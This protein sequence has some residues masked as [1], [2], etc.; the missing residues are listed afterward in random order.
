MNHDGKRTGKHT[1]TL[2]SL[3]QFFTAHLCLSRSGCRFPKSKL[4]SASAVYLL[5][6]YITRQLSVLRNICTHVWAKMKITCLLASVGIQKL[7]ANEEG[8]CKV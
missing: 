8:K 3:S 1:Q 4:I 6:R 2:C 5:L 7:G